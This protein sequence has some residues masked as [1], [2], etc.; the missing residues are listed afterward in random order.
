MGPAAAPVQ[1]PIENPVSPPVVAPLTP[2]TLSPLGPSNAPADAPDNLQLQ[3]VVSEREIL[4][5]LAPWADFIQPPITGGGGSPGPPGPAGPTGPAGATGATG[6]Q[7]ATGPTGPAGPEGPT[8]PTGPAG[9][10]GATGPAGPEGPIGPDGAAGATGATGPQG[11]QG[12]PPDLVA[13]TGISL[14]VQGS[15][16]T[17]TNTVTQTP[18]LQNI[19]GGAFNLANVNLANVG[20]LGVRNVTGASPSVPL[21]VNLNAGAALAAPPVANS[22]VAMFANVDGSSCRVVIDYYGGVSSAP[23]LSFRASGGTSA[24]QTPVAT[25]QILGILNSY[26]YNGSAYVGSRNSIGFYAAE[27]WTTTANGTYTAFATTPTGSQVAAERMRIAPNGFVGIAQTAPAHYLDLGQDD[28]A[29]PS[30]NTWTI[31]SDI[32][33]KR[34]VQRFEGDIDVIRKLDPIVAEYNGLGGTPEGHRVVSFDAQEL[35]KIVPQCVSGVRG[36]LR[37]TDAN[38]TDLL[39]INTHELFF[40]LIRAVQDID[41]R[42]TQLTTKAKGKS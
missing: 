1:P 13:G 18:W 25:N 23:A 39:G 33:T 31:S 42:L 24:A 32:R 22:T 19:D 41:R 30:T 27:P 28:A 17:I 38:E 21:L 9:T 7:G 14:S 5:P 2:S 35:R 20:S 37:A 34:N 26:G 11:P 4:N 6:A 10:P 3:A 16:T 40:H 12:P 8:G 15:A 29:K 36:K